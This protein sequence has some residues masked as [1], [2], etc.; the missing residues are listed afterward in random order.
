MLITAVCIYKCYH[1]SRLHKGFY[2]RRQMSSWIFFSFCTWIILSWII[3]SNKAF[4]AKL[5]YPRGHRWQHNSAKSHGKL[6]ILLYTTA[7]G[8]ELS[9]P[10]HLSHPLP[11]DVNSVDVAFNFPRLDLLAEMTNNSHAD[12]GKLQGEKKKKK[13]HRC[14]E[15]VIHSGDVSQVR[16]D[17]ED[18]YMLP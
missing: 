11:F 16:H 17:G 13:S 15:A 10:K 12:K 14:G 3:F 4:S 6:K 7:E 1:K 5:S 8:G 18:C 2:S 9:H